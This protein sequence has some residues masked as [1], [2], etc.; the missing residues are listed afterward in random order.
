LKNSF[1]LIVTHEPG[2]YNYRYVLSILRDIL[3]DYRVVDAGYSVLL[4]R[5]DDP[6]KAIEVLRDNRDKLVII[7]RV[8]PVDRILDPYVEIIADEAGK[9]AKDKIPEDKTYRVSLRGRLYW[10]ET[11]LPAHSIDAIKV[12]AE[13][14]PR[15]VSLEN[16]D[17]IV[18]VRSIKFYHRRRLASLTVT[19]TSNILSLKSGKP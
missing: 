8:I 4:L 16:P 1:N 11:R 2:P 12:I 7:Y 19:E 3:G 9:L 14:I 5:V 18:Y 10:L 15:K 6:Y 13:K 17:Y